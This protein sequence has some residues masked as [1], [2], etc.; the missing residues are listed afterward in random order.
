LRDWGIK[1]LWIGELRDCGLGNLGIEGLGEWRMGE[2]KFGL[3]Q[4]NS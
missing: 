4:Y 3:I 2:L 1:G